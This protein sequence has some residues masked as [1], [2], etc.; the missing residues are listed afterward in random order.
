MVNVKGA[1]TMSSAATPGGG[2]AISKRFVFLSPKLGAVYPLMGIMT[3]AFG[4][5]G[6][7]IGRSLTVNPDV[8][9]DK[10]KRR[11]VPDI[12]QPEQM[13]HQAEKFVLKSPFRKLAQEHKRG[14]FFSD[15]IRQPL[16]PSYAREA[17]YY[18]TEKP[19]NSSRGL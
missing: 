4:L 16:T 9:V 18:R 7:T 6:V 14:I 13:L 10:R 17:I 12:E 15:I 19:L 3:L 8:L 5:A 1:G 11:N 2:A